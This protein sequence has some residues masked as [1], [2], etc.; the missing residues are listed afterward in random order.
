MSVDV[1]NFVHS[2]A[3][4]MAT[5]AGGLAFATGTPRALWTWQAVEGGTPPT[6]DPYSVLLI[7]GG[8]GQVW[9]PLP[10]RSVQCRTVGT[11]KLA[12]VARAQLLYEALLDPASGRPWQ[13]K[14]ISGLT[15]A[16]ASDG[17][18][19]LVSVETLGPP[20]LLAPDDRN[21]AELAF[22]FE[23]GFF[24]EPS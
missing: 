21:R 24:K 5:A 22:N 2:L 12:A 10:R 9:D 19:R 15:T 13:M 4:F 3:T 11:S 18:W 6:D 7:F 1:R 16:G 14:Q 20:G 17:H 23:V 8:A